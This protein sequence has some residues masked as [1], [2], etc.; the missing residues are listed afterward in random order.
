MIIVPGEGTADNL[1]CQQ[2]RLEVYSRTSSRQPGNGSYTAVVSKRPRGTAASDR[3]QKQAAAQACAFVSLIRR[4]MSESGLATFDIVS[5]L[6]RLV[7]ASSSKAAA[8][9]CPLGLNINGSNMAAITACR[10]T[11]GHRRKP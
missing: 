5:H 1:T 11:I 6:P 9:H 3:C 10:I 7:V 8:Y 2:N 4:M